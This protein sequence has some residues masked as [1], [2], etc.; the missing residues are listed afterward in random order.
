MFGVCA[1]Q[2]VA[3]G[4][5]CCGS[6]SCP[7]VLVL[8]G[9]GGWCW[10]W[11][12]WWL[13]GVLVVLVVAAVWLC[14]RVRAADGLSAVCA[15]AGLGVGCRALRWAPVASGGGVRVAH[16]VGWWAVSMVW[17]VACL[18]GGVLGAV[19]PSVLVPPYCPPTPP[20]GTP[21]LPLP[22]WLVWGWL[23][24]VGGPVSCVGVGGVSPAEGIGEVAL[25]VCL[26]SAVTAVV[27]VGAGC[28][29][30]LVPSDRRQW[31]WL[32]TFPAPVKFS[33][34]LQHCRPRQSSW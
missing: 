3:C 19:L 2:S 34:G 26:P 5:C 12:S 4:S 14:V 22:W 15:C 27:A 24:C 1:G 32:A 33:S 28:L 23:V 21:P 31:W 29:F 6:C 10:W 25:A 16:V 7:P 20:T 8:R 18:V 30:G 13:A 17:V 9:L 11:W